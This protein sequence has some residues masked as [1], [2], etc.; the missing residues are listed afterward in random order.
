MRLHSD[1]KTI[2]DI[3]GIRHN[4]IHEGLNV[5]TDFRSCVIEHI[6]VIIFTVITRTPFIEVQ[7]LKLEVS[8]AIRLRGRWHF[9]A[10][11]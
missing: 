8:L 2:D 3:H 4:V 10:S 5:F 7:P 11:D 1:T 9:Y 6:V